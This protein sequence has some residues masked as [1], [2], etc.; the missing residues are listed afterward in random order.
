MTDGM[1]TRLWDDGLP[2]LDRLRSRSVSARWPAPRTRAVVEELQ[3][4]REFAYFMLQATKPQLAGYALGQAA[5]IY[6]HYRR[7][8]IDAGAKPTLTRDQMLDTITIYRLTNSGTSSA[9]F[10]REQANLLGTRNNS[11]PDRSSGRGEPVSPRNLR[12]PS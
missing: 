5:W 1:R 6:D 8:A 12:R 3:R 4:E 7:L 9:R 2:V 11:R 10:Y